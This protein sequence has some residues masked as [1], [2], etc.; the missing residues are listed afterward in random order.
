MFRT[1]DVPLLPHTIIYEILKNSRSDCK[2]TAQ[3]SEEWRCLLESVLDVK[4]NMY[5]VLENRERRPFYYYSDVYKQ[6]GVFAQLDELQCER[7]GELRIINSVSCLEEETYAVDFKEDSPT[8]KVQF[9]KLDVS[10]FHGDLDM[11]PK[12]VPTDFEEII[13][14]ISSVGKCFSLPST[15]KKL[16]L[17][18]F[19]FSE[20]DSWEKL[21]S[22][23]QKMT[24]EEISLYQIKLE[25]EPVEPKPLKRIVVEA[26]RDAEDPQLKLFQSDVL[27]E[28]EWRTFCEEIQHMSRKIDE[29]TLHVDHKKLS[30][31]LCI[32]IERRD[33][34][35]DIE[36]TLHM[37]CL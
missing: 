25:Q 13:M 28:E 20:Q 11:L 34:W 31:T 16:Y 32:T 4:Y 3:V 30:K 22:F 33:D 5:L 36:R 23:V 27:Q 18:N 19:I 14:F 17:S 10:G 7:L 21:L 29:D 9:H 15:L 26:W 35:F 24:W 12:I 8:M 1:T 6:V 2:A 37:T